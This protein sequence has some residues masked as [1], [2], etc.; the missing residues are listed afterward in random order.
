M[1]SGMNSEM[2]IERL[3]RYIDAAWD[4]SIVPALSEYIRIPNKS[5]HFDP[6]WEQHGHMQRA[7]DLMKA[8]CE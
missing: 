8:W 4:Q 1:N 6:Q 7:A 5:V 2:N 3:T